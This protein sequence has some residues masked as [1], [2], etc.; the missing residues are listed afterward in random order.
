MEADLPAEF[1][2]VVGFSLEGQPIDADPALGSITRCHLSHGTP[3]LQMSEMESVAWG[4]SRDV[5]LMRGK[6]KEAP[7]GGGKVYTAGE[8]FSGC[9]SYG[10]CVLPY[11]TARQSRMRQLRLAVLDDVTGVFCACSR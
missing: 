1:G 7:N 10:R 4:D 8:V 11:V 2:K 3:S 5:L 9:G 6:C